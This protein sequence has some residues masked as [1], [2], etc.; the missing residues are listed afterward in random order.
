MYCYVNYTSIRFIF[1]VKKNWL[2]LSPFFV[3]TS[4]SSPTLL[5][6]VLQGCWLFQAAFTRF[7]DSWV[8][9]VICP[10]GDISRKL[11]GG[12]KGKKPRYFFPVPYLSPNACCFSFTAFLP[13]N[14]SFQLFSVTPVLELQKHHL[15]FVHQPRDGGWL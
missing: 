2:L 11:E 15:P 13:L 1:K 10:V 12:R 4:I 6:L 14:L 8:P 5:S 9:A 7:L 3:L